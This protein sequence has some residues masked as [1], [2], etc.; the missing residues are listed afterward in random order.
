MG[1]TRRDLGEEDVL[2]RSGVPGVVATSY[3]K[4]NVALNEA[5]SAG[6]HVAVRKSTKT[7]L[8]EDEVLRCYGALVAHALYNIGLLQSKRRQAYR[9]EPHTLYKA[10]SS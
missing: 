10:L 1:E 4:V 8:E 5:S 7:G 2:V 9:S 3:V 6:R